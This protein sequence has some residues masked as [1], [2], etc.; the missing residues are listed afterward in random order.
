MLL[1]FWMD[2]K[3]EPIQNVSM[4]Y[5]SLPTDEALYV[6][7]L[8]EL[9]DKYVVHRNLKCLLCDMWQRTEKQ[10]VMIGGLFKA[11]S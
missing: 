3:A 1:R 6:L 7:V 2:I 8:L 4:C 10:E 11:K 5:C 9:L